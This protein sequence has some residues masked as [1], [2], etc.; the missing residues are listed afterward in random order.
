MANDADMSSEMDAAAEQVTGSGGDD[1]NGTGRS[2]EGGEG[3]RY[4]AAVMNEDV[5]NITEAVGCNGPHIFDTN[6]LTVFIYGYVSPPLVLVTLVTNCLVCI[7]LLTKSARSPTNVLLVAMAV[8]D[9]LTGVWPVPFFVVFYTAGRYR[10]WIPYRWC[11]AY[12]CLTEYLPT[13]FHTAS[14]WLTVV[15]AVQRYIYVCHPIAAK[16]LCT[17]QNVVKVIAGVYVTSLASQLCRFVEYDFHPIEV[18]SLSVPGTYVTGCYEVFGY[19]G[20]NVGVYFQMYYWPRVVFIHLVPCT[21]LVVLNAILIHA[22]KAAQHRRSLLLRQNRR[23]EM[24]RLQESNSTTMM[25]VAVVGLFLLVE[26][27]LAIF[28]I[29][30]IWSNSADVQLLSK[31]DFEVMT[32]FLNFFILL[33]YPLNFFIYWAM[34]RHFRETFKGLFCRTVK[35]EDASKMTNV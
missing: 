29:A 17:I 30:L 3:K 12:F 2:D 20:I 25:L 8:S 5:C 26:F 18:R 13:V 21:S 14:I 24:R 34:S 23:A 7:V 28:L 16:R 15:L 27:P 31:D 10:D 4:L 11:F 1:G 22:L 6:S 35:A 32:L 19:P 9:T 33:S